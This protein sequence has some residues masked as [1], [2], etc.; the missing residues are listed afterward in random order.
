MGLLEDGRNRNPVPAAGTL[1]HYGKMRLH[2]CVSL[3][4]HES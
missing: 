3:H 2:D 4:R 1:R